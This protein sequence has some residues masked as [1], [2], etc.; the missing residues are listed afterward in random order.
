MTSGRKPSSGQLDMPLV[1]ELE[2]MPEE[3]LARDDPFTPT[4]APPPPAGVGR[5]V[6]AALADLG[7]VLLSV[8]AVWSIA[9]DLGATLDPIRLAVVGAVGLEA[10][11][12]LAA[13]CLWAWR[14]TPGLLLLGVAFGSPLTARRAIRLWWWWMWTLPVAGLPMLLGARGRR[15]M[16]RLAEQPISLHS[17]RGAA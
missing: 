13:G 17:P 14:G 3:P 5:L 15:G 10:A 4:E 9:T 8:A 6:L 7:V 1:W 11:S 16:E 2:P 12:I